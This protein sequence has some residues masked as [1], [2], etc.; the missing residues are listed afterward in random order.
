MEI[1][2]HEHSISSTTLLQLLITGIGLYILWTLKD[3]ILMILLSLMFAAALYPLVKFLNRWFSVVV[4]TIA[5]VFILFLPLVLISTTII[6]SFISEVPNL[7]NALNAALHSSNIPAPFNNIDLTQLTKNFQDYI[8]HSTSTITG[9][10]G[11]YLTITFLTLYFMIDF[12][13]HNRTILNLFPKQKRQKAEH[14]IRDMMKINGQYIRGNL[15]ISLICGV[16]T[17]LGLMILRVPHAVPLGIFAAITD[18]LPVIG[19]T[20]GAIPAVVLAFSVSPITGILTILLFVVYQQTEN[21]VLV[22]HIYNRAL[23]LSP[24]LSIVAVLIGGSLFGPIGAFIS[25]PIAASIPTIVRYI[26]DEMQEEK[27]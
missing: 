22:P 19:A 11:M 25:L 14:F 8:V 2:K 12:S 24:S 13:G 26:S 6:P 16:V 9:L 21:N 4:S 1:Q 23:D 7:I 27:H 17:L 3:V 5:V 20:I 15:L 10:I 18:V